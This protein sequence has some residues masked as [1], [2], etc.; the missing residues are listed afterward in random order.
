MRERD[1]KMIL[2]SIHHTQANMVERINRELARCFRAF[3]P[4]NKHDSWY[5]WIDEIVTIFNESYHDKIEI[6]SHEALIGKKPSRIW[7]RWIPQI[8]PNRNQNNRME[9]IRIIRG[10]IKTRGETGRRR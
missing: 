2:T 8:R 1:I 9:L 5:N 10:K 4:E 3:L 7:E 6:T